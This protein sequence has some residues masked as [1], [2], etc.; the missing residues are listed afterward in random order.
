VPTLTN[1]RQLL[2]HGLKDLYY[3]E[4]ALVQALPTLADEASDGELKRGLT[5]HLGE[6]KQQ[7]TKLERVFKELGERPSAEQCPGFDGIKREHDEFM[8]QEDPSKQMR[9]VFLTGAAARTEHY[10]I[11]AYTEV[12]ALARA[13]RERECVQLLDENLKQEKQALKLAESAGRR[14]S[15]ESAKN[16]G[17]A[18]RR[19]KTSSR[20]G[21]STT[22]RSS[23]SRRSSSRQ[24]G[25][26]R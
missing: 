18:S 4:K 26:S 19:R 3:V 15:R 13:L 10:E 1:P 22:S 8:R 21:R 25:R 7:V 17:A 16:G 11:A 24:A 5:K 14:I 23:A 20:A 12:I 2:L 6:T 9:D